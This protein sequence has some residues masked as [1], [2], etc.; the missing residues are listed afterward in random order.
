MNI[1]LI[2]KLIKNKWPAFEVEK[3]GHGLE[4]MICVGLGDD[5]T[6]LML[7]FKPDEVWTCI[8]HGNDAIKDSSEQEEVYPFNPAKPNVLEIIEKA[9]TKYRDKDFAYQKDIREMMVNMKIPDP[10]EGIYDFQKI[11]RAFGR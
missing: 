2:A 3:V 10:L 1:D 8:H 11:D 4:P 7:I 5:Y 6:D 9:F